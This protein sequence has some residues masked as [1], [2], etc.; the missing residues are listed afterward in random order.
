[1]AADRAA[2][3]AR[4]R[5]QLAI[6]PRDA[7]S[8]HNLASAEGDLGHADEAANAARRALALGIGAPETR[9]VLARALQDQGRLDEAER[10]FEECVALR[11]RYGEAHRD[12]AQLRWMRSGET[13]FALKALDK[14]LAEAPGDPALHLVRSIVLEFTG[15]AGGAL[16]SAQAGVSAAAADVELLQQAAHL[17]AELG[18][19]AQ[20]LSHAQ[21]AAALAP[22]PA[23]GITLCEALLAAG[24]V[25]EAESVAAGLR[26]VNPLDQHAIALQASAWRLL[27][28]RRYAEWHD[29]SA[30]VSAER[31]EPPAGWSTRAAFLADL[32]A[33]LESLHRFKSH[34][35]QQSVRGGSQLPLHAAEMSRPVVKALFAAIESMVNRRLARLGRG[36]DPFRSQ[37]TGRFTVTGAWSIRLTSGGYHTDH[38]HPRG[39]LSAVFYVDIPGEVA[40]APSAAAERAGWLRFGRA[41]LRTTPQLPPDGFV[42][43][44]PGLLVLFPAYVWHG[45]EPFES[46]SARLSV[47]LDALP[48]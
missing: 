36:T 38:V 10:L 14:A 2:D 25:P 24:R 35:F 22:G 1:M 29:Y 15:D 45:V 3:A 20:A 47:A 32:R 9:F 21:R 42:Q 27:G 4:L 33:D 11:P 8:W 23:T 48:A 13:S 39:W 6:D 43:P 17:S 37:N 12:L 18:E 41:G 7:V 5:A 26:A 34:P 40:S 16:A 19:G 44:E 28:D 30:L 31:I 46:A